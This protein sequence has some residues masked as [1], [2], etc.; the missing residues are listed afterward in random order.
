[1]KIHEKRR[2]NVYHT[3]NIAIKEQQKIGYNYRTCYKKAG[4]YIDRELTNDFI[5]YNIV[6]R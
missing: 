1:M 3:N 5:Y 6:G 2:F 4:F